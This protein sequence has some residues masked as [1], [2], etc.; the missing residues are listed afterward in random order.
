MAAPVASG[1]S[2]KES[3]KATW[4]RSP[5][6]GDCS[7]TTATRSATRGQH[8]PDHTSQRSWSHS[9]PRARRKRSTSD[10][11]TLSSPSTTSSALAPMAIPSGASRAGMCSGFSKAGYSGFCGPGSRHPL[12]F[13]FFFAWASPRWVST[14]P[15]DGQSTFN[16]LPSSMGTAR[17]L[18]RAAARPA[19]PARA[20]YDAPQDWWVTQAQGPAELIPAG[21]GPG[22]R[23]SAHRRFACA[24][25]TPAPAL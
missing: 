19:P 21:G 15:D 9:T 16:H 11:A 10:P 3:P 7:A 4:N 20:E 8:G 22:G 14:P 23:H 24:A 1:S 25:T 6:S 13:F 2:A 18:P 17:L 5:A 12:F